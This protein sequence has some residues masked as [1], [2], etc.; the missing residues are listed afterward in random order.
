VGE[1]YSVSAYDRCGE[2]ATFPAEDFSRCVKFARV[3]AKNYP[4]CAIRAF[5]NDRCD[6]DTNGLTEDERDAVN[7]AIDEVRRG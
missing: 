7:D 1:R 3:L 5:N 6:Y 2:V 4:R